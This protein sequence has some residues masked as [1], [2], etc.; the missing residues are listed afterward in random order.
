MDTDRRV[1]DRHAVTDGQMDG[2][3]RLGDR[4]AVTV[5]WKDT[6]GWIGNTDMQ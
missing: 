2:H 5:R 1:G 3:R 6:D 4:H